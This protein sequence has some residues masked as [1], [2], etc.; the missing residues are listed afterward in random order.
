MKNV[1]VGPQIMFADLY[2][3]IPVIW[4]NKTIANG[5]IWKKLV[6]P[7]SGNETLLPLA[8]RELQRERPDIDWTF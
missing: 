7:V 4:H 5:L 3:I 6:V 1:Y 8:L 2:P